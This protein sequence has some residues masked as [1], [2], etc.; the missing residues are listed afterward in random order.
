MNL[1]LNIIWLI[2]G[3]FIVVIAYLLGGILLCLTIVGIR[4]SSGSF[5]PGLNWLFFT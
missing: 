4:T 2:L 1:L 5:F 3:G